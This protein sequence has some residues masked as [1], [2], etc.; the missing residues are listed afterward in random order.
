MIFGHGLCFGIDDANAG[1]LSLLF[2]VDDGVDHAVGLQRELAR[3]ER[4]G[5]RAGVRTEVA[6]K[7]ATAIAHIPGLTFAATLF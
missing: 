6:A 3:V 5:Y 2:V 4:P 1:G 7:G